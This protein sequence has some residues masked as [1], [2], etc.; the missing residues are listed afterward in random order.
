MET[1]RSKLRSTSAE[2][3]PKIR[4]KTH[5]SLLR[6]GFPLDLIETQRSKLRSTSS[7]DVIGRDS[8]SHQADPSCFSHDVVSHR[9]GPQQRFALATA[10]P[11]TGT[12]PLAPAWG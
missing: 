12:A 9:S 10:A 4:S 11:S 1:Q 8:G 6:R 3:S 2:A 7:G 5:R